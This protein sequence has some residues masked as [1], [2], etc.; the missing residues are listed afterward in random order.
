[1]NQMQNLDPVVPLQ[2]TENR[3]DRK[4]IQADQDSPELVEHKVKGLLE[5]WPRA[6]LRWKEMFLR[7][8]ILYEKKSIKLAR[9]CTYYYL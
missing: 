2:A 3:W 9:S 7:C 6:S 4:V 1:M 5:N 8:I